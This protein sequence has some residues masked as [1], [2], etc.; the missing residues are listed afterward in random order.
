MARQTRRKLQREFDAGDGPRN[1]WVPPEKR[2]P[3]VPK[4]DSSLTQE[5][6]RTQAAIVVGL[7]V[8][9]ETHKI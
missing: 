9:K 2:M 8:K 1:L 7:S 3:V 5:Q 4:E 6:I